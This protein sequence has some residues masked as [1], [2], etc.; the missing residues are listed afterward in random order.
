MEERARAEAAERKAAE[1]RRKEERKA[2]AEARQAKAKGSGGSLSSFSN[3]IEAKEMADKEAGLLD[4]AAK[5]AVAA[6]EDA[7]KK[8]CIPTQNVGLQRRTAEYELHGV[9]GI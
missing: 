9:A 4:S 7:V 5:T 8:T 2:A 3:R 1:E 6:G